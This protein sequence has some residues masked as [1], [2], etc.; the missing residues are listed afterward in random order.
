LI[1]T[2]LRA[3]KSASIEDRLSEQ[4]V[5]AQISTF[6]FAAIDTTS[7]ALARVIQLLA[8]NPDVQDKLREEIWGARAR[9][10]Q[11]GETGGQEQSGDLDYDQID[12]LV[13]LDAVC[14]ETLRVTPPA[15]M[16]LK[17]AKEA[18]TLPISSKSNAIDN[19][20]I[21]KG[22]NI[23]LSV[24]GA[25]CNTEVW[26]ED[27]WEWRPERWLEEKG[28]GT[29]GVGKAGIWSNMLTFSGGVKSCIGYKFAITEIKIVLMILLESF[30][31]SPPDQ[32]IVWHIGGLQSPGVKG[33]ERVDPKLPL[34]V[35]LIE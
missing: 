3:N 7:S 34:K 15:P 1:S 17:I 22:T 8:E 18:T 13:Y 9:R 5:T 29:K 6:L 28:K 14:R 2:L 32:E 4:E 25:N 23:L 26:G 20:L 30:K 12:E 11:Q 21:P 33:A 24:L 19:I 35:S 10:Q 31:F 27:G 16:L